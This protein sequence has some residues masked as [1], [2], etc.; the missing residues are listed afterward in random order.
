TCHIILVTTFHRLF[1][2]VWLWGG[3]ATTKW[4]GHVTGAAAENSMIVK[5]FTF[6]CVNSYSRLFYL[7]FWQR[8]LGGLE[9]M[10]VTVLIVRSFK[11]TVSEVIVPRVSLYLIYFKRKKLKRVGRR[12]ELD[13][14]E[15]EESDENRV[16]MSPLFVF[17]CTEQ[18]RKESWREAL[19][20]EN[21]LPEYEAAGEYLNLII[22][23]NERP[24]FSIYGYVTMFAVAFPLAPLLALV[25]CLAEIHIDHDKITKCRRPPYINRSGIGAW[26]GILEIVGVASVLTNCLLL[27]AA[28]HR[29]DK[30]VPVAVA[31]Q[32]P[33]AKHLVM[34]VL[35]EHII[36]GLKA[37]MGMM[38]DDV[39]DGVERSMA[40][41]MLADQETSRKTMQ[42]ELGIGD[43]V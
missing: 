27:A 28:T 39:P 22:Q 20:V 26:Y 10:L 35:V 21:L 34:A 13:F 19:E 8:D 7:G 4:E 17:F 43:D 31:E 37:G 30:L 12:S 25:R 36:L 38:I 16:S 3:K 15:A 29:M 24:L 18:E 5:C 11:A 9:D 42:E 2:L 32:F 1:Y 33:H 23:A 40:E 14:R 41:E 6:Q